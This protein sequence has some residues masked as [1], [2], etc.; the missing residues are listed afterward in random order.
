[1]IAQNH[2]FSHPSS[3]QLGRRAS[4]HSYLC[5]QAFRRVPTSP[6]ASARQLL[7][8]VLL[9]CWQTLLHPDRLLSE[10]LTAHCALL[11]TMF[12]L[13]ALQQSSSFG[14]VDCSDLAGRSW[15]LPCHVDPG[16]SLSWWVFVSVLVS[17]WAAP[18]E[19][20]FGFHGGPNEV[21]TWVRC[22]AMRSS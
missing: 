3:G 5:K 19:M 1:M 2:R 20:T 13:H 4:A 8:F 18:A 9:V 16:V 15:C 6:A 10:S 14:M 17:L 21:H 22:V 11:F 7:L 12:S